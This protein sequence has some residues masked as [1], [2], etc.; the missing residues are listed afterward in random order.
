[1]ADNPNSKTYISS[2]LEDLN[3][4][5]IVLESKEDVV[6]LI[7]SYEKKLQELK[8]DLNTIRETTAKKEGELLSWMT[9]HIEDRQ[10]IS[11]LQE[12]LRKQSNKEEEH[13]Y[14]TIRSSS[15]DK[16]QQLTDAIRTLENE[17]SGLKIDNESLKKKLTDIENKFENQSKDAE[18]HRK[19]I[20]LTDQNQD[21]RKQIK[22]LNAELNEF[23]EKSNKLQSLLC[24]SDNGGMEKY[25]FSEEL[26][27]EQAKVKRIEI[28]FATLQTENH[29]IKLYNNELK[30]ELMFLK[31]QIGEADVI[32]KQ[33]DL[34]YGFAMD[35]VSALKK[36]KLNLMEDLEE[37]VKEIHGMKDKITESKQIS[38]N[39]RPWSLITCT[40][41][42][43]F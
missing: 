27:K 38:D 17:N 10:T 25:K 24:D 1:M 7:Q 34:E 13:I 36:E 12:E 23:K 31:T 28:D 22:S 42:A 2:L 41:K 33:R 14:E 6:L 4:I 43:N 16:T 30:E 19:L 5:G 29:N 21:L 37:K 3:H 8:K 9:K 39:L 15:Q 26:D 40:C 32:K 18:L 11:Q 35:Q 20:S